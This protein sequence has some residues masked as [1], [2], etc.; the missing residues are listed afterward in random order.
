MVGYYSHFSAVITFGPIRVEIRGMQ[1]E[2]NTS[3]PTTLS[4]GRLLY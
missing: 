1:Y 2:S 3:V 4:V